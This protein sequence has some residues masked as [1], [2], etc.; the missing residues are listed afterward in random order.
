MTSP[1]LAFAEEYRFVSDGAATR[2]SMH[3]TV[4][5]GGSL[6]YLG[7]I[8]AVGVRRQVRADHRRLKTALEQ[9]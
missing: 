8:V 6:R 7:G 4:E 5:P 3:A 9:P 2:V 1:M